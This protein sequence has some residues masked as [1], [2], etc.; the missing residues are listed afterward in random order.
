MTRR[1]DDGPEDEA[2]MHDDQRTEDS[3]F[4]VFCD[5]PTPAG[6][7]ICDA[8]DPPEHCE[9]CGAEIDPQVGVCILCRQRGVIDHDPDTEAA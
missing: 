9:L 5:G 7:V 1:A 2:E 4:C 3:A 6:S 8:C